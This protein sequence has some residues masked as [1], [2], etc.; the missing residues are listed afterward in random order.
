MPICF[1]RM[2]RTRQA[3][4]QVWS[5]LTTKSIRQSD[6][7]SQN[8]KISCI[9][10]MKNNS[11]YWQC[12]PVSVTWTTNSPNQYITPHPCLTKH[13]IR[14][15]QAHFRGPR[16]AGGPAWVISTTIAPAVE[17]EDDREAPLLTLQPLQDEP[18]LRRAVGYYSSCLIF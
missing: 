12:K 10:C 5:I 18:A 9:L 6:A 3:E 11:R 17:T 4:I 1:F 14:Y 8:N 15:V 16:L 7:S 2:D 13:Y